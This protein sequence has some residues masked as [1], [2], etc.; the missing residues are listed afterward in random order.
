M[1]QLHKKGLFRKII[2]YLKDNT[3][4]ETFIMTDIQK[5][6]Y[7]RHL[8]LRAVSLQDMYDYNSPQLPLSP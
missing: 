2:G 4:R 1:E 3:G 7:I 5:V 6:K 8:H